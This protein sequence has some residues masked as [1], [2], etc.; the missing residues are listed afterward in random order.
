M[1]GIMAILD[2]AFSCIWSGL[3]FE[4]FSLKV[5]P[6]F[7]AMMGI[8]PIFPFPPTPYQSANTYDDNSYY[9][10]PRN[11]DVAQDVANGDPSPRNQNEGEVQGIGFILPT[12]N[13]LLR[14]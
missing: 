1:P 12:R 11:T 9:V 3:G 7:R 14:Y 13:K 2:A 8:P 5:V 6:M 10:L 4:C